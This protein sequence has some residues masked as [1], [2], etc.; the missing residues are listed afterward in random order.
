M[1]QRRP[2]PGSRIRMQNWIGIGIWIILGAVIGLVMRALIKRPSETPGHIIILMVVG[3]FAAVI[4][5][6]LGVGVFHLY[7]PL[8]ISPG[9]MAGGV[10]FSAMITFIY[11]WGIRGLI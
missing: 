10:I 9:G 11:R 2:L 7:E 5:G 8:A 6:M 1:L 4:G 3:S